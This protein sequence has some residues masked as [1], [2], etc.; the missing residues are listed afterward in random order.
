MSDLVG[1]PEDRFSCVAAQFVNSWHSPMKCQIIN[2]SALEYE[3]LTACLYNRV[4]FFQIEYKL[5]T[6]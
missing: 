1:N 4:F 2:E 5:S 6:S 3:T